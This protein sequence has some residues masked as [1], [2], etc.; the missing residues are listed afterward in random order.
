[1]T[2]GPVFPCIGHRLTCFSHS[3]HTTMP[4]VVR[5]TAA[6]RGGWL[7]AS[8]VPWQHHGMVEEVPD[9][10]ARF[11]MA[12]LD[13]AGWVRTVHDEPEFYDVAEQLTE[14][15]MGEVEKLYGLLSVAHS[16]LR[17]IDMYAGGRVEGL[18][19]EDALQMCERTARRLLAD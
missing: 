8:A 9:W 17:I 13:A 12:T 18:D 11:H 4:L 14:Y 7:P 10:N 5:H 6:K 2:L 16:L 3:E 15:P 1:M 19:G